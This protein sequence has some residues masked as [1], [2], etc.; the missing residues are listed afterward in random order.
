MK[1]AQ[2]I[3]ILIETWWQRHEYMYEEHNAIWLEIVIN[4]NT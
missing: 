3:G 2:S 1:G 4:V